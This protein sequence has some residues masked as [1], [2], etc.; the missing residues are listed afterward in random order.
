MSKAFRENFAL[1]ILSAMLVPIL[2]W[3]YT[4]ITN[5]EKKVLVL[6]T[7]EQIYQKDIEIIRIKLE[8][9]AEKIK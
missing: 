2:G 5:T 1:L 3:G 4:L 8:T 9:I 7:K 6:E